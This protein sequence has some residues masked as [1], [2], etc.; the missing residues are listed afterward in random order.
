L[1]LSSSS[2]SS[3]SSSVHALSWVKN[4]IWIRLSLCV[5]HPVFTEDGGT[6]CLKQWTVISYLMA[7]RLRRL[8]IAVHLVGS[9][10]NVEQKTCRM[11]YS[12]LDESGVNSDER[13]TPGTLRV[14]PGPLRT[15]SRLVDGSL[16]VHKA[17]AVPFS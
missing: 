10:M 9:Q 15:F 16:C 3:S 5:T 2:S 12:V 8:H 13:G 1:L 6:Y 14:A 17:S 7:D 4:T 11:P